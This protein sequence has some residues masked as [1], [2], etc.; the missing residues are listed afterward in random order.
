MKQ[1]LSKELILKLPDLDRPFIVQTDASNK[2][3]ELVYCDNTTG[4]NTP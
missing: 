1:V 2:T 3:L 4:L